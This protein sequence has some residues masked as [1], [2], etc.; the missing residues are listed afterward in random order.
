VTPPQPIKQKYYIT[1]EQYDEE[2]D[3]VTK[4]ELKKL[5]KLLLRTPELTNKTFHFK[6][7][8]L[9][10]KKKW[11]TVSWQYFTLI[12]ALLSLILF[13]WIFPYVK[14]DGRDDIFYT[15]NIGHLYHSIARKKGVF[16][17]DNN[18]IDACS[19]RIFRIAMKE[20]MNTSFDE[21]QANMLNILWKRGVCPLIPTDTSLT[22]LRS[23]FGQNLHASDIKPLI[24]YISKF[25][26]TIPVPIVDQTLFQEHIFAD[27]RRTLTYYSS[28]P[29]SMFIRDS[30]RDIHIDVQPIRG[31]IRRVL[32]D[33]IKEEWIHVLDKVN[34]QSRGY[35]FT[36]RVIITW[37][38]SDHEVIIKLL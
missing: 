14:N 16:E 35:D 13:V 36:T 29:I 22:L 20:R 37:D 12:T 30:E 19:Y 38:G 32:Y 6:K 5:E 17:P 10:R 3:R 4:Y 11:R 7:M 8:I 1:P 23:Y 9:E 18:G 21:E 27:G 15:T 2:G 25:N 26:S 34:K 24:K 28:K 31:N 33:S